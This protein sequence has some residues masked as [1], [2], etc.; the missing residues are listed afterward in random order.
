M[1]INV[2]MDKELMSIIKALKDAGAEPWIVGGFVR[3]AIIR[4]ELGFN[5]VESKDMDFEVFRIEPEKLVAILAQHARISEVG[6]SFAVIKVMLKN[7]DVVDFSMPR[8]D[9]KVASGHKG[10]VVSVDPWMS[11][12]DAAKRRDFRFNAMFADPIDGEVFDPFDGIEDIQMRRLTPVSAHFMEDPLRV[13]RGMQFA[14]RFNM[15]L[16]DSE[17]ARAMCR[18][19]L[20]GFFDLSRERVAEEWMKWAIKGRVPS[21]GIK[22]LIDAG[23]IVPEASDA[24]HAAAAEHVERVISGREAVFNVLQKQFPDG[25]PQKAKEAAEATIRWDKEIIWQAGVFPEIARMGRAEQDPIWHP[26][27]WSFQNLG[28]FHTGI[29]S[30]A[31][32]TGEN[33]STPLARK[34]FSSSFAL[35]ATGETSSKA[36][37]ADTIMATEP[38]GFFSARNTRLLGVLG[39]LKPNITIDAQSEGFVWTFGRSTFVA[40]EVFRVMFKISGASVKRIVDASV[41]D[42]QIIKGVVKSV[43]VFVMDM[44]PTFKGSAEMQFHQET[45]DTDSAFFG[46]PGSVEITSVIVDARNTSVNGDVFVCFDFCKVADFDAQIKAPIVSGDITIHN[47]TIVLGNALVHTMHVCDAMASKNKQDGV[48]GE[49]QAIRMFAALLHDVGKP[50][51]FEIGADGRIHNPAHDEVGEPIAR[52][53]LRK[54]FKSESQ[55]KDGAFIDSVAALVK[56]HMRHIGFKGSKPQVRK[57]AV[58]NP[59]KELAAIVVADHSGRPWKGQLIMPD[60]MVHMLEVADQINVI[61]SAPKPLVMGRDL[62]DMGFK[63]GKEFGQILKAAFAAQL[64]G[65]FDTH[66]EGI[67]WVKRIDPNA[68]E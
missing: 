16:A 24:D 48:S 12:N 51:T 20:I 29:T 21:A 30:T 4:Q 38:T 53:F 43:T 44:L 3:D 26:E 42:L 57:L 68:Q 10:F 11:K 49:Q 67:E 56:L 13:L 59:I 19:M 18:E 17:F 6:E 22:F 14:A 33:A 1:R 25:D 52:S 41:N 34:L 66:E 7:G 23:W 5:D 35:G 46:R 39:G 54:L 45:M 28:T 27:G 61:D 58:Q 2:D 55:D 9:N 62:I 50:D 63:P 32:S 60:Q 40:D 37:S 36:L 47:C 65:D 64:E 8:K 31:Q 15:A